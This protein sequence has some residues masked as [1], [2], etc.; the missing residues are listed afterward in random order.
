[1]METYHKYW[2]IHKKAL[3]EELDKLNPIE[4]HAFMRDPNGEIGYKVE[5]KTNSKIKKIFAKK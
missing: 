4:C 5:S 3:N 1:M 2:E